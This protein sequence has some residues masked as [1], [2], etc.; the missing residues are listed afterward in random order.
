[1]AI[2]SQCSDEDCI[3]LE[4]TLGELD[5]TV[6]KNWKREQKED[7]NEATVEAPST[8]AWHS[9]VLSEPDLNLLS[10]QRRPHLVALIGPHNVGKTTFL[11]ATHLS[12]LRTPAIGEWEFAG[13]LTL[14]GW[15]KI[16]KHMQYPQDVGCPPGFPPH[17]PISEDRVPG[18][19]HYSLRY[20][21]HDQLRDVLFTDAPGEWFKEW[22]IHRDDMPY[23]GASWIAEH[24]DTFLFFV[25]SEELAGSDAGTA[26]LLIESISG[27]LAQ[28]LNHRP[29]AIIWSK[30][31]IEIDESIRGQIEKIIKR[32][33]PGASH[34]QISV[35]ATKQADQAAL[36]KRLAS[37][38]GFVTTQPET[39]AKMQ[40]EFPVI[41]SGDRFLSYRGT[42]SE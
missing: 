14:L 12:L 13:S 4:C 28:A 19:L 38:L 1:V 34:F 27:R 22:A 36:A 10:V 11:A 15:Q 37:V 42:T 16:I 39:R 3:K 9:D 30:S 33:L 18:L 24:A 40:T 5:R 26:R 7:D 35:K 25:D 17:T 41:E 2:V 20:R 6:C 29:V 31:D 8:A 23:P 21:D 32:E